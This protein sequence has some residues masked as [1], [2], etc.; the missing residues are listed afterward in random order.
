MKS[1]VYKPIGNEWYDIRMKKRIPILLGLFL[2]FIAIWVLLTPQKSIQGIVER[3]DN[4]GYDMQLRTR[5]LTDNIKPKSPVAII[6]IDEKSLKAEGHWPWPRSKLADLVT[7]L[8]KQ[9]AIVIA[10]DIVFPEKEGNIAETLMDQLAKQNSLDAATKQ[11]LTKNLAEF[12]YDR[13]FAQALSESQSVLALAFTP[14]PQTYNVLPSPLLTLSPEMEAQLTISRG[15]GFV[16]SIPILQNAAKLGGFINIF[17]D[18]DGIIRRAPMVMEYKNG[19]Y[20]ALSLQ[21]VLAYLGESITLVTPQYDQTHVLEGIKLSDRVIP[22]D[23]RGHALIPFIGRS[24]TFPYYSATD[25]LHYNLPPNAVLGKI[26]FLGTSALGL[27]DLQPTSIQSP[28]PG[29]EIQATLVNGILENNF[30]YT[31]AWTNGA[32]FVITILLGLISAFLFP[33]LGPRVL[34]LIIVLLPISL[35]LINN[36]IWKETGLVLSLL[37]PVLLTIGL[38]FLN[39][40]YGYLFESRRREQLKRMFGQYVPARHI[41]QM[42]RSS[43]DYA[44]RGED[45]Q[46]SVLFADIRDFTTISEGLS[47]AELV[48]LLNLYLNPMT[49]VIFKHHGTIDKYVGDMIMAFW[50]A[51]L[52]DKHHERNAIQCALDMQEKLIEVK[53]LTDQ[54]KWP[55]IKIGIGVNSGTMSVGDMGSKYRRNYTVLGDAVNLGSRVE[56]LTKYYGAKII[57]TESTHQNQTKFVFRKLDLVKV[58]GKTKGVAIYEVLCTQEKLSP[59]LAAELEKYNHALEFYFNQQWDDAL[60]LMSELQQAYPDKKIYR[61]YIDRIQEFKTH[62]PPSGWDGVYVHATK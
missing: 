18:S 38:A 21:A 25:A 56:S 1:A 14:Q 45:R 28:Y 54:N 59:E 51:P 29:V 62:T 60:K 3:L 23:A 19:V 41:D 36:W 34:G 50:G 61:L 9:G 47:A 42:L 49:E 12:D 7:A 53:K 11:T 15:E 44:L 27:G 2:V 33:Y 13:V 39:I 10:F 48:Q 5:V 57:V 52:R 16:G 8:Q 20:P 43:S 32:K 40:I 24:F 26:L 4:L 35:L 17:H 6:D 22:T 37:I 30:S 58:K 46:M 31:P 55:E